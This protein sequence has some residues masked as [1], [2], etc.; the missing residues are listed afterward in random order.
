[1]AKKTIGII[2][3]GN[4]G[5]AIVDAIL[6]TGT[7]HPSSVYISDV[8]KQ[9]TDKLKKA[10]GVIPTDNKTLTERSDVVIIAVKPDRVRDVITGISDILSPSKLLIS[11]AAGVSTKKIEG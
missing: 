11:I 1:M 6:S 8:R 7:F 10:F 4:M 9:Q 2:G 5:S 3:C